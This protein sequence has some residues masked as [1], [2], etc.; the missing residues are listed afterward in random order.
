MGKKYWKNGTRLKRIKSHFYTLSI[1]Y[2]DYGHISTIDIE[3]FFFSDY[4]DIDTGC[5]CL[6]KMS[7][8][9]SSH[10]FFVLLS[11]FSSSF[12]LKKLFS[13]LLVVCEFR[14][15][16]NKLIAHQHQK[17]NKPP[18][19]THRPKLWENSSTGFKL[20]ELFCNWSELA[21]SFSC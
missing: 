8:V 20:L 2:H 14:F 9:L 12:V 7:S 11:F 13:W 16:W 18:P 6:R 5:R 10:L 4:D 17:H 19:A 21:S 15:G 3:S 1:Y